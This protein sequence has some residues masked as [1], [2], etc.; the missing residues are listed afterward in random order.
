MVSAIIEVHVQNNKDINEI[1]QKK[2]TITKK[3]LPETPNEYESIK[4]KL[5]KRYQKNSVL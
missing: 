2:A 1:N 4:W 3:S 5:L